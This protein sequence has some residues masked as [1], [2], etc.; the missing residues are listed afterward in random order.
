VPGSYSTQ[1][2][3]SRAPSTSEQNDARLQD[4]AEAMLELYVAH[5]PERLNKYWRAQAKHTFVR[6]SSR[7]VKMDG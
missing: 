2:T 6:L 1:L 7:S 3:L 5:V 4:E